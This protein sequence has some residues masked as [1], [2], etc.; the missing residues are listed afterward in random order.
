VNKWFSPRPVREG[1][2]FYN[3]LLALLFVGALFS[4]LSLVGEHQNRRV[5]NEL[6]RISQRVERDLVESLRLSVENLESISNFVAFAKEPTYAQFVRLTNQYFDENPALM[7]VEWQP[8]VREEEREAFIS[9]ARLAGLNNFDIW[10]PGDNGEHLRAL[11]REVHIPVYF[12]HARNVVSADISTLGL[13]LAWS[14]ERLNSKI[15]ARDSGR[16]SASQLFTAITSTEYRPTA[17]AISLPVFEDGF[18]PSS[19]EERR[20]RLLGYMAGVFAVETVLST[21]LRDTLARGVTLTLSDEG[22]Q[23]VQAAPGVA[24]QRA[25][26]YDTALQLDLY[27]STLTLLVSPTQAFVRAQSDALAWLIPGFVLAFGLVTYSFLRRLERGNLNLAAAQKELESLNGQLTVLS[28]HDPLTRALNRRAFEERAAEEM[29]RLDRHGGSLSLLMLDLDH[30]KAINDRWGH[31]AGDLVLIDFTRT[32]KRVT[33]SID[34]FA[35]LGGEE[36]AILLPKASSDEARHFAERL[37][38]EV[39]NAKTRS[40]EHDTQISVTVSIGIATING[41]GNLDTFLGE[42]DKALYVAKQSGR[43][44]VSVYSGG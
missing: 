38:Q 18:T 11:P 28:Q 32:C 4:S 37:R 26:A 22:H 2:R 10:E 21:R 17:F 30:F 8:V 25:T 23:V 40:P 24:A 5:E 16:A 33:R 12:M 44:R 20:Q 6:R 34:T 31:K 36:F 9:R 29:A 27:G 43:N 13:D 35:R 7:I 41:K 1:F 14:P 3:T 42:A 39:E 19:L 15:E